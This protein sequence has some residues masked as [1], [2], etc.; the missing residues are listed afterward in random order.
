MDNGPGF[1]STYVLDT[2]Q[3]LGVKKSPSLPYAARMNGAIERIWSTVGNIIR[4]Y[5]SAN[6]SDWPQI[7]PGVIASI[8]LSIHKSTGESPYFLVTGQEFQLPL[9]AALRPRCEDVT[10]LDRLKRLD[11]I[12]QEVLDKYPSIQQQQRQTH[13]RHKIRPPFSVGDE[14]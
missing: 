14:I 3:Q 8:N 2:L 10:V 7:L 11:E 4:C 5:A 1:A 12:R 6:Q 13:N 9:D